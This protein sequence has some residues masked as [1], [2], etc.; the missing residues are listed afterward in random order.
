MFGAQDHFE[1]YREIAWSTVYPRPGAI[2]GNAP[3]E[4]PYPVVISGE[5]LP[6]QQSVGIVI[7]SPC[8]STSET[9]FHA[10]ENV[11]ACLGG[12]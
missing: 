2:C 8:I 11:R 1:W 12:E 3:R 7:C 9:V 6:N 10:V 4:H 5:G